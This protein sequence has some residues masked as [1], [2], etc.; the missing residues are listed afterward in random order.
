MPL[1]DHTSMPPNVGLADLSGVGKVFYHL[2]HRFYPVEFADLCTLIEEIVLREHIILVGK[3]ETTPR[4][5]LDAIEP[6]RRAAVFQLL[7]EPVMPRRITRPP[8]ELIAAATAASRRGLTR[9]TVDDA[10]LEITR[11]LGAEVK[12]RRPATVLMRNLHN[13]GV[14]RRPKFEHS[15]VDLVQRN[16][17]LASNARLLHAEIQRS[18]PPMRGF[19]YVDAPPLA[20]AVLKS[21]ATFEQLIERLLDMRDEH[22]L[23]RADTSILYEQ[24]TD[25]STSLEDHAALVRAWELKWRKSWDVTV[26]SRMYICNTSASLIAKGFNIV[27][28]LG[29]PSWPAAFSNAVG[30]FNDLSE[31]TTL[32]AL[33]PLHTPVRDYLVAT[34][35]QMA[36]AISRVWEKDPRVIDALMREI[37]APSSLWRKAFRIERP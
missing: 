37:A 5:Y 11:L 34:R 27:S 14:R 29:A 9:A 8:P 10:D 3:T 24:L 23:L 19:T 28:A 33:R 2:R 32:H 1:L 12:L 31:A 7:A 6:L 15:I 26:A 22:A 4:H 20:L 17:Q 36:A 16:R 30:I 25:P 35:S 21:A 18:G 13:F